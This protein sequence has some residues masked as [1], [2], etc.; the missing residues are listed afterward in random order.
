[1]NGEGASWTWY[2][3]DH[4]DDAYPFS[5]IS[6]N[7][8]EGVDNECKYRTYQNGKQD[9]LKFI[10]YINTDKDDIPNGNTKGLHH[11]NDEKY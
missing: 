11:P 10:R 7:G 8:N 5:N 9:V 3:K 6:K 2:L 4:Q 1:M